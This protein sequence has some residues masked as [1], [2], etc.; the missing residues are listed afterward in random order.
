MET[1]DRRNCM[2]RIL[3]TI[4]ALTILC[5]PCQ[6]EY[7]SDIIVT[8]PNGAWIDARAYT[9][10]SAAV[11][12]AGANQ[13]TIH[14]YSPLVAT[15]LTVGDNVA[16]EFGRDGSISNTGTL[17]L[18]KG[19]TGPDRQIFTGTGQI[20]FADGT[21][22]RS[23]WF[24]NFETALALTSND[25]VTLIVSKPQTL[26]ASFVVGTDVILKWESKENVLTVGNGITIS[27]IKNI[28]A[29]NYQIFAGSGTFS[30]V[31]GIVLNLSWFTNLRAAL[32]WI[33]ATEVTLMTYEDAIVDYTDSVPSTILLYVLGGT[34]DISATKI[35]TTAGRIINNSIIT[36]DG[37]LIV[38]GS[39]ENN[40][41]MSM[42][43]SS[44]TGKIVNNG[45]ITSSTS[46]T[47]SGSYTG[48]GTINTAGSI[49][50][51]GAVIDIPNNLYIFT[52][53]GTVTGLD[54]ARPEW[55]GNVDGS[56]E[57]AVLALQ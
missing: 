39:I 38:S 29:G 15:T 27:N 10:L 32:T 9:S 33:S 23:A 46:F 53:A 24:Q 18:P 44:V 14:I 36:G 4:L 13:R 17:T 30:F 20:D 5:S 25:K 43:T 52:G 11:T 56:I 28:E 51:T 50:L 55:W 57:K 19:F 49:V 3:F 21:V 35:L 12:A 40:G 6:A 31:N 47:C 7:F 42:N 41:T 2:K 1:E 37:T 54:I 34:I 8:G 48:I 22:V 16:F 45:T 26:T